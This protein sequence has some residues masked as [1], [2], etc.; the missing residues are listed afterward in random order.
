MWY[1]RCTVSHVDAAVFSV[2]CAV[3]SVHCA[4]YSVL[5]TVISS[6]LS[7]ARSSGQGEAKIGEETIYLITNG[8]FLARIKD[9]IN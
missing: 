8:C 5:C 6:P 3:I 1:V 4:V 7:S 2:N 9:L